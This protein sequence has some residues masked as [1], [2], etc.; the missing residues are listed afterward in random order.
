MEQQ[1]AVKISKENK[2]TTI[3]GT[4]ISDDVSPSFE[5]L[6]FKAKHD[7]YVTPGALVAVSVSDNTFLVARVTS[8]HEHNPHESSDRVTLRDTM[9]IKPDYPGEDLSLTIH[10]RYQAEIIDEVKEINGHYEISPPEK[11]PKSG[12]DIFIPPREV[13]MNIMGLENDPKRSLNIGTLAISLAE[14]EEIPVK[15]KREIIQR[16]IFIGGTTGGGKSYAARVIAEEIHKHGI[17]I[18]FFDTQYE[19]APLTEALGGKVVVPG[20]DYWVKLFSLTESEL[21]SLIPTI[22]HELHVSLLTKAFFTLKEGRPTGISQRTLSSGSERG[23]FGINELSQTLQQIGP[24]MEAKQNTIDMVVGRTRYYL[25]S[26]DFLGE[27]FNWQTILKTNS[28]VEINCKDFGR[29]ALQLILASTLREL[30]ELRKK[31]KIKPFVILDMFSGEP[32]WDKIKMHINENVLG[33]FFIEKISVPPDIDLWGEEF[34]LRISACDASQHRFKLRTPFNINFSSPVVVNNSAGILKERGTEK[35]KWKH[36]AVPKDT[37]DFEDWVIVG[38]KDYTELN[39]NDY[40]WAT[41]SAMDVGQFYVEETYI[42][43][44]GGMK[45][46][47]DIHFRDG[48]VFPQDHAM[49]CGLQ[50]RHGELTREAIYRMTTTLRK[51][52]ELGI[53]FCGV[54]KQ[55]NLKLYSTIVDWYIKRKMGEE[56]WNITGHILSDSEAMRRMLCSEVFEAST[57]KEIYITCP[58]VRSFYTTSNLNRRTDKQVINDLNSLGNIYHSRNLTAKNIAEEAMKYKI[59]MFFVGHSMTPEVYNWL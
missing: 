23:D 54:A 13:I 30:T 55:V 26:Y 16:H 49:N 3:I 34:P 38:F 5:V 52:R 15:I 19:F 21:L 37:K 9:G 2:P 7:K 1:S 31:R 39:E 32:D 11:M 27:G 14:E 42:F 29:H 53:I 18:I 50:N 46:K 48:R 45:L 6:R 56:N 40:E 17:P 4:I 51:A 41:K 58:I 22:T 12:S 35:P 47:P 59:A 24:S 25:G 8:S 10:R 33:D 44:Y 57:F 28:V 36:I 43:P 20:K